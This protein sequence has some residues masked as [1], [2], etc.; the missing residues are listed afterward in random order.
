MGKR[1][2]VRRPAT[3]DEKQ[4]PGIKDGYVY[5][6][7]AEL[8]LDRYMIDKWEVVYE[9]PQKCCEACTCDKLC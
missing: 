7:I 6:N 3:E 2:T 4:Y 9:Q 8:D 1:F 5:H